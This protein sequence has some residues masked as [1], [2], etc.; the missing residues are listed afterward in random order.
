MMYVVDDSHILRIA[1]G[2]TTPAFEIFNK[3]DSES[4][5]K[6]MSIFYTCSSGDRSL[7]LLIHNQDDFRCV[8]KVLTSMID[9]LKKDKENLT[10]DELFLREMWLRADDNGDG[11]LNEDEIYGLMASMN[12]NMNRS[13]VR[14]L[15][16]AFDIDCSSALEL[17]EFKLLL[18]EL[19]KRPALEDIWTQFAAGQFQ[20]G[21]FL[22]QMSSRDGKSPRSPKASSKHHSNSNSKSNTSKP[23]TTET[24]SIKS[25]IS[26]QQYLEFWM[27]HQGEHLKETDLLTQ[28]QSNLHGITLNMSPEDL[29]ISYAMWM[30]IITHPSNDIFDPSKARLHQNM[31]FPLT[32]YYIA[33]SHNTYLEGDQI[34]SFSSV[35]RYVSDLLSGCRCVELDCW[36]GDNGAPVIYHGH[37]LTSKILFQGKEKIIVL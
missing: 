12:I 16:R 9:K 28:L 3:K 35:N 27:E 22:K 21:I 19:Q 6:S 7:D 14:K 2:Q 32:Y 13:A 26:A 18:D 23:I 15:F 20:R 5:A 37:T 34:T 11:S 25:S 36:N 1:I 8:N 17:E 29:K 33:S 30:Q 24:Y 4:K 10:A 31:T